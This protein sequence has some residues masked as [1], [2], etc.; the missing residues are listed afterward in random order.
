MEEKEKERGLNISKIHRKDTS[1]L[2]TQKEEWKLHI[3]KQWDLGENSM[4][5]ATLRKT[6]ASQAHGEMVWEEPD[7]ESGRS[8]R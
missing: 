7:G 5:E 8:C 2:G 1:A 4:S 3:G 6:G